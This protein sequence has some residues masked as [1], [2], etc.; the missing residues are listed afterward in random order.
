MPERS[1]D[2]INQAKRDL[3][4]AQGLL[5]HGSFEWSCFVA[6]QAGEK[7]VKGVVQK[8]NAVAWGQSV[9]EMLSILAKRVQVDE[10]LLD[11]ARA[12]DKYYIPTR[13]PNS[14]GSGSPYEYFSKEDAENAIVCS[15]R[16][17]GFCEGILA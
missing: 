16:I 4:T 5:D 15:G 13:Y 8:L 1:K 6:Q 3:D 11:C 17:A 12:L 7:A 14:F 2:W 10:G 9:H